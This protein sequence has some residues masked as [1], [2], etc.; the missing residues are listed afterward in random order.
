MTLITIAVI[1]IGIKVFSPLPLITFLPM[2]NA[3]SLAQCDTSLLV[4]TGFLTISIFG[5]LLVVVALLVLAVYKWVQSEQ[6]R[7]H[8]QRNYNELDSTHRALSD[9]VIQLIP[10][11][12]T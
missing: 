7:G 6:A 2:V 1:I 8:L 3:A 12:N 9:K 5:V 10:T 11:S 4:F